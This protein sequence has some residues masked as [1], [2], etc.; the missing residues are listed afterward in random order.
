MEQR[1]A[2]GLGGFSRRVDQRWW[3]GGAPVLMD[4]FD[5]NRL[6]GRW[7]SVKGRA[8]CGKSG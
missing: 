2:H 3:E 4:D 1:G 5:D 8:G 7:P 6:H